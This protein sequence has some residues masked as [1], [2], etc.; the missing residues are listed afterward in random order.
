MLRPSQ[1]FL[2]RWSN[3]AAS[4]LH[5][6]S[7]WHIYGKLMAGLI[8]T[9]IS[10]QA[11]WAQACTR[12]TL[13]S[14]SLPTHPPSICWMTMVSF[15]F[16]LQP[17]CAFVLSLL[18]HVVAS[19]LT[20]IVD[21]CLGG[22]NLSEKLAHMTRDFNKWCQSNKI[23]PDISWRVHT[24]HYLFQC[25]DIAAWFITV[26]HIYK[27]NMLWLLDATWYGS[28]MR[29]YQHPICA[30]LI[31]V[32]PGDFPELRIKAYAGRVLI[33]FLQQKMA[34]LCKDHAHPTEVML[35]VHG[36][37][38]ALCHWLHLVESAQ[39]YLSEDEAK[40]IWD[41]SLVFLAV[42]FSAFFSKK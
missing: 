16:C 8:D 36:T 1:G 42:Y 17:C 38:S 20:K 41:T 30:A 31:T 22:A 18:V 12:F 27:K 15:V 34:Q 7:G 19:S 2:P 23:R 26:Q 6:Q 10:N 29:H 3:I 35:M 13:G 24:L 25:C 14:C 39:R 28:L 37:I 40:N 9:P 11:H 21:A 32:K 5:I 4:W 33:S